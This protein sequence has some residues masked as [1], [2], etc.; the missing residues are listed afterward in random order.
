[1]AGLMQLNVQIPADLLQIFTGPVA[2]PV[3][4]RVG[5]IYSQA[6]VTITVSQ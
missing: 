1:V 6:N 3:V 4:V 5:F 2:V